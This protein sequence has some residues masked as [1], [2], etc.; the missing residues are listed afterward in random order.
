M[1]FK[2]IQIKKIISS[3]PNQHNL[4]DRKKNQIKKNK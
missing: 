3:I 2:N 1:K 4:L